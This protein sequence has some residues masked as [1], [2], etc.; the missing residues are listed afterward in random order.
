MPF[1]IGVARA[2]FVSVAMITVASTAGCRATDRASE[3][4]ASRDLSIGTTSPAVPSPGDRNARLGDE[5]MIAGQ[6]FHTGAPV[7]L[8]TDP[9]G[10]DA[11]R[12]EYRFTPFIRPR[13]TSEGEPST[14]QRYNLR[15]DTLTDE[16]IERVRG[17]GWDL[18]TLQKV[19]DQ[20][21][22]HYDVCGDSR[23]CFR[24]LHDG[25]H[26]SV[27]FML[28]LDGTIY[29]T[30]D[31]KERAWHATVSNSRSVG[32]EIANMG[33]YPSP[34]DDVLREWY[35][36]EGERTRITLPPRRGDGALRDLSMPLYASRAEPVSGV[37]QGRELFQY[38]LTDAQYESLIKLTAT[39]STAL[40][41]IRLEAPR[42]PDGAVIPGVLPPD[43][44][45]S[46]QGVLGHYHV[47]SNKVDP[48]PAFDWDRVLEGARATKRSGSPRG[49]WGAAPAPKWADRSDP[50]RSKI[51]RSPIERE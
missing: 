11:Y 18:P 14:P 42:G 39:L 22:M 31:L 21:V 7:V 2:A 50:V 49:H 9:G 23:T 38:D 20:F 51:E 3:D 27:H 26:L 44:L 13:R 36:R 35:A 5:I 25:R 1:G 29:Q 48:G 34:D 10:Y 12:A 28:D 24:V 6:L 17:G 16:E 19:V 37:I 8:W 33:A 15:A 41:R 45:A 32:I 43:E 47:Q 46:F 30:L 40:P 4:A